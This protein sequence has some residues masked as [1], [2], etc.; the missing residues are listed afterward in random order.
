MES[1]FLPS[2]LVISLSLFF[3]FTNGFN[4]S[5]N[6]V[7]SVISSNALEPEVALSLAALGNFCGAYFLG[8]QVAQTIV[9]DMVNLELL[10][11]SGQGLWMVFSALIGALFWNTL[12]WILGLPSSSFHALIGGLMGSFIVGSGVS[13]LQWHSLKTILVVMLLAPFVGFGLTYLIT[14]LL[15]F[16]SQWL[17]RKV[18]P[19]FRGVQVFTLI[20]Q[21][22]MHGSNDAQK[23]MGVI[24]FALVLTQFYSLSGQ[25]P[26]RVPPWVITSCA[27]LMGLGVLAGARKIIKTLGWGLYRVRTIHAFAAQGSSALVM[28]GA[29]ILGFPIAT[30]QVISSS[31]MGAGAAFRPK[32]VRWGL[33]WDMMMA[34]LVTIPVSALVAGGAFKI[35]QWLRSYS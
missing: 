14:K 25:T 13:I 11:S 15:I 21:S 10:Q 22:F 31:V 20:L 17:T 7:S 34:W 19:F 35:I 33:A 30:S 32:S 27:A 23:S 1:L 6:Q 5:A 12:G 18:N 28:Y 9:K 24:T 8:T 26:F 3:D 4:D 2:L 16:L 29:S